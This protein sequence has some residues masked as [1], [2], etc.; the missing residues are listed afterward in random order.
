MNE[1][2]RQTYMQAMGVDCYVP[3]LVLPGAK[4]S[5]LCQ[6]PELP[7][8]P[9]TDSVSNG[10]AL[11]PQDQPSVATSVNSNAAMQALLDDNFLTDKKKPVKQ[12]TESGQIRN[13]TNRELIKPP[14]FALTVTSVSRLM[15]IDETAPT[16]INPADYL[17]Y[18]HNILFALGV[19]GADISTVPFSWPMVSNPNVDQSEAAARQTLQAFL[20][21]QVVQSNIHFVVAMGEVAT[22][23]VADAPISTGQ[24]VKH[25]AMPVPLIFTQ[26]AVRSMIDPTL[27]ATIWHDLQ[28]LLKELRTSE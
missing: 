19:S 15:L 5:V 16:D 25:E 23:F 27:K 9:A 2:Q 26:S 18:L 3:R 7:A 24:I 21:K 20:N 22:Q 8:V 4:A 13:R 17:R 10:A 12:Q 28:P 1:L 11:V 6:L 14:S